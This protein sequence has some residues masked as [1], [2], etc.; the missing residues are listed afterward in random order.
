MTDEEQGVGI[1]FWYFSTN[2]HNYK[3]GNG[4]FTVKTGRY[5]PVQVIEVGTISDGTI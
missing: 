4:D 1:G 2:T 3:G 5:K